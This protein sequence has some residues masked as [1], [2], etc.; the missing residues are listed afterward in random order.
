MLAVVSSLICLTYKYVINM[1]LYVAII[2]KY[3]NF[4]YNYISND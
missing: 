3:K 2:K 1:Q 4:V